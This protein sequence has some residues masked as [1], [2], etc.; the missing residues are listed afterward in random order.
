MKADTIEPIVVSVVIPCFN[1]HCTLPRTLDSLRAQSLS[2]FE[3][4][5]VDDGSTDAETVAFLRAL[6]DVKVV[7]QDNKGLAAARNAGIR[8]A[9][10]THVLPLDADDWL[11]PNAIERLVE[12]LHDNPHRAYAGSHILLHGEARGELAKNY[13]FFEQ[14]FLNQM[15]YCILVPKCIWEA[16]GGYNEKMRRG[17]EDWE[18]NIR[19]GRLGYHGLIVHEP[20]FH[21]RVSRTGMLQSVSTRLHGELWREIQD[22][23]SD[24]YAWSKLFAIWREWRRQPSTYPL[25]VYFAWLTLHRVLPRG[26]FQFLFRRLMPRSHAN[27]VTKSWAR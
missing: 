13:N 18:F 15:P 1:A 23:H 9:I 16:A 27:R 5:L 14:L 7:R 8:A 22:E 11:A 24:L 3:I 4:V 17:Y 26:W 12:S 2:P 6:S 21:Y 10:G 19:L 20:L 25:T